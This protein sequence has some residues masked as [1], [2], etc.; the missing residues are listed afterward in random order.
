MP[1]RYQIQAK[2]IG[3]QLSR[4]L[5]NEYPTDHSIDMKILKDTLFIQSEWRKTYVAHFS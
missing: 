3:P 4:P 5:L 2:Q 1:Q